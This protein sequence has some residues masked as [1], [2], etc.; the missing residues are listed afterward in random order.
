MRDHLVVYLEVT[1]VGK[2]RP[3]TTRLRGLP[4]WGNG[5]ST[6]LNLDVRGA[7]LVALK[8]LGEH[9]SDCTA[10]YTEVSTRELYSGPH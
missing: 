3:T 6:F 9:L 7:E 8:G 10:I 1:G 5:Q 4:V 2:L